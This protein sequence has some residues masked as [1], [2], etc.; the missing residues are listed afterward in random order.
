MS[1]QPAENAEQ[2]TVAGSPPLQGE[3]VAFTGTLASMTHRQAFELV[4]RHGGAPMPHVSRQT[5][6]LVVGEEG[7]PLDPD[8]Q[9]SQKMQQV[10]E[11]QAAGTE[12]RVLREADWLH[13]IGLGERRNDVKRLHTPAMLSQTLGVP[14]SAIRGWERIGL[15]RPVKKVYRLPYFDFEEVTA[16]RRLVELLEAGVAPRQIEASLKKI[17]HLLPGIERPLAQLDLLA[18]ERR[19]L[20]RDRAGL[21]ESTTGQRLFEFER[22]ADTTENG[23]NEGSEAVLPLS[24]Q[25]P[26]SAACP[27]QLRWTAAEW[28]ERGCRLLEQNEIGPAMEAL[29]MS[30]MDRPGDSEANFTLA[31]ALYRQGN[32]DGALERYYAAVEADHEYIEVWTQIG[33][34]Y[35]ERGEAEAALQALDVALSIHADYPDAHLHKAEALEFLGRNDEASE[36]WRIYLQHD[37]HGPWAEKARQRLDGMGE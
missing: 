24:S 2:P 35:L 11:L 32:I 5:T 36:H 20:Y 15:I 8:G 33:C 21:V 25:R 18:S 27:A 28:F 22:K 17:Q 30:L 14:V 6:M 29:R 12:V 4:E 7:W 26:A 34:V 16:A 1:E 3:R 23:G 19:L 31:E 9:P 37:Q 10:V 13:L